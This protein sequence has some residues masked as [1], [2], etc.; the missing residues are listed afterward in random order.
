MVYTRVLT[1]HQLSNFEYYLYLLFYNVIYII[2]LLLIVV[3][4]VITLGKRKL[5]MNEGRLLKLLSGM[6]MFG[7]GVVLLLKPELLSNL[8]TGVGLLIVAALVT[9]LAYLWL[10]RKG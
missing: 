8:W 2:P 3:A 5:T 6:M 10:K 7:L 9:A 1:M 4:F